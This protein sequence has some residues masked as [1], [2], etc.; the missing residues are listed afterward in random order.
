[1]ETKTNLYAYALWLAVFTVGYNFIEG[2][3]S[4]YF[5]MEDEA[6]TLF[7]F[8]LDS[9]IETI[10]ALGIVNM[11]YRLK[12]D[13]SLE[14]SPFE[15]LALKITGWSFYALAFA[16]A[17]G[18]VI[19][20]IEQRSPETTLSGIIISSISIFSMWL[21]IKLKKDVGRKLGSDAIIA[22]ANCN[23]VCMYMSF[24]LLASSLLFEF[25]GIAY[26]DILGA[27]GLIWFSVKE[28]K[29]AF[30]KAAGKECGCEDECKV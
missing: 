10:S 29:E 6:L 1:M 16:L 26:F 18:A 4:V 15:I 11:T 19:G 3:V 28:G 8:G 21:L 20:L 7:G 5:G 30:E 22:D 13:S 17:A 14:R 12:N 2:L 25:T 23:L 24:I 9:F 27:A